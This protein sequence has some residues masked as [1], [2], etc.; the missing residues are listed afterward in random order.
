MNRTVSAYANNLLIAGRAYPT[1]LTGTS[2]SDARHTDKHFLA[3]RTFIAA[4]IAIEVIINIASISMH[5]FAATFA[6][7]HIAALCTA[8]G[9]VV[10]LFPAA[11][12]TSSHG[13]NRH[14]AI[15]DLPFSR[16]ANRISIL[17]VGI[18]VAVRRRFTVRFGFF[19]TLD[20]PQVR[21]VKA[22][23]DSLLDDASIQGFLVFQICR[24]QA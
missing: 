15:T 21:F 18:V 7:I 17:I 2:N 1:L 16:E 13:T 24:I 3:N 6:D 10:L 4:L 19:S 22:D 5:R 11:A 12:D 23:R 8:Y 14:F 9:T 20:R